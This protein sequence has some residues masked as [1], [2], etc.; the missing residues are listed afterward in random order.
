MLKA[1][2]EEIRKV[3]GDVLKESP[4]LIPTKERPPRPLH[5]LKPIWGH[6]K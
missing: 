4:H 1:T 5:Q 6:A 3:K 2:S